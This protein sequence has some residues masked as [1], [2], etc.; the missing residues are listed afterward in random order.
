MLKV[1]K[2]RGINGLK[3]AVVLKQIIDDTNWLQPGEALFIEL[4][5]ESF[6]PFFVKEAKP[7]GAGEYLLLL[8]DIDS[9]DDAK[10]L[11]NKTVYVKDEVLAAAEVDSPLL[12]IGFNL[13]DKAKGGIGTIDDVMLIGGQWIAR[14]EIEGKEV[15][16]PLAE[17]MIIEVNRRN[18]YIRMQLPD[19]LIELYLGD[20]PENEEA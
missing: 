9:A 1:G 19:G 20:N 16:V 7:A 10:P 15:L 3:G 5:R 2:I 4:K 6:I 18:K 11:V 12:Y 13:V 14:L 17:D 8:D